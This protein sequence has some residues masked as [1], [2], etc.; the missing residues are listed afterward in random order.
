MSKKPS[1]FL[2]ARG[3][4]MWEV[5]GIIIVVSLAVIIL[6][7]GIGG[8][9]N[10]ANTIG[11]RITIGVAEN[12]PGLSVEKEKEFSGFDV[13]VATYIAHSLGYA[14][15]EIIWKPVIVNHRAQALEK[16]EVDIIVDSYSLSVSHPANVTFSAP[17][18]RGQLGILVRD[19]E[20]SIHNL[21]D[22]AGKSVCVVNGSYTQK[23][24][25]D[26]LGKSAQIISY[27]RYDQCATALLDRSVNAVAADQIILAGLADLDG[28]HTMK[29]LETSYGTNEW[30]IAV[31][32]GGPDLISTLNQ[33][34]A[35]MIRSGLWQ[36]SL[37]EAFK[38]T[39]FLKNHPVDVDYL[40]QRAQ[41]KIPD[42]LGSARSS[43]MLIGNRWKN[44]KWHASMTT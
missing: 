26:K 9:K 11:P 28:F 20:T 38:N 29:L 25:E 4:I 42:V 44:K 35:N 30:G 19:G 17:Y 8:G 40:L 32:N 6:I 5:L 24:I 31:N 2:S 39:P 21:S 14:S 18:Y 15:K 3:K 33:G 12:I 27:P 36:K 13:D 16:G 43:E 41:K 7:S 34:I 10:L 22:L 23:V 37:N 1:F